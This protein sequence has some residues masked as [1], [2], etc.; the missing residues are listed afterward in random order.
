MAMPFE[1]GKLL[2][3]VQWVPKDEVYENL[4]R[5]AALQGQAARRAP[6]TRGK[7]RGSDPFRDDAAIDDEDDEDDFDSQD[8]A[9]EL[10]EWRRA[11]DANHIDSEEDDEDEEVSL[12]TC[13]GI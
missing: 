2:L 5:E 6:V 8:M 4:A 1:V 3:Q 9:P 10:E 7:S 13:A 11:S 12:R